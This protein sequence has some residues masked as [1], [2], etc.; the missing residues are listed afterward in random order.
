MEKKARFEET[1]EKVL[2]S[3]VRPDK[4]VTKDGYVLCP[5]CQQMKL[6][7]LPSDGKVKA[8]AYCRHCRE[9]KFL[10]IDLSLSH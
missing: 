8:F 1:E 5:D 7:R 9:E 10:N 2:K 3:D 4:L 6:L